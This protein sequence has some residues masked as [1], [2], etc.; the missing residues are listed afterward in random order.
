MR[1]PE[2]Q[3]VQALDETV[4]VGDFILPVGFGKRQIFL[5]VEFESI[6]GE[7]PAEDIQLAADDFPGIRIAAP[8]N[9]V[10]NP[11]RAIAT[12]LRQMSSRILVE[13]SL[14]LG[15]GETKRDSLVLAAELGI[16]GQVLAVHKEGHDIGPPQ[17]HPG[18][19]AISDR[20]HRR[21][22]PGRILGGHCAAAT[23]QKCCEQYGQQGNHRAKRHQE[24]SMEKSGVG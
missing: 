9:A 24:I 17:Y 20:V 5:F 6:L 19:I 12:K 14:V 18:V 10:G 11:V 4:A 23:Q 1:N 22:F 2:N 16:A 3:S 8:G 7:L 21:V 15:A 13:Q